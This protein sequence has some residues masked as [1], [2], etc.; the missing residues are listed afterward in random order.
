MAAAATAKSSAAAPLL[1]LLQQ[2]K[3]LNRGI[4]VR[5]AAGTDAYSENAI[6]ELL[7]LLHPVARA[8]DGWCALPQRVRR[9]QARV[10]CVSSAS[11]ECVP[12]L[13][14][15]RFEYVYLPE[16]A[17]NMICTGVR[18]IAAAEGQQ[19]RH[20]GEGG[21]RVGGGDGEGIAPRW[22]RC[23]RNRHLQGSAAAAAPLPP[24]A[25]AAVVENRDEQRVCTSPG[26]NL[27]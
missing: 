27:C 8:G 16:A 26:E 4:V 21:E 25:A 14:W 5:E 10:E 22:R 12:G 15:S 19:V 7:L 6:A 3:E 11:H 13:C 20:G 2:H 17:M 9:L 23:R 1:K 18:T 24:H